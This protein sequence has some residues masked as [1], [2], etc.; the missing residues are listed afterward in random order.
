MDAWLRRELRAGH[1]EFAALMAR[2]DDQVNLAAAALLVARDAYPGL[3]VAR[4]LARLDEMAAEAAAGLAPGAGPMARL[5]G[6][7]EWYTAAGFQ[8]NLA[9]YYD[10]RN[11][12]LNE[13]LDRRLGIPITLGLVLMEVGRR[14][15]VPLTAAGLP[16]HVVV[17][18]A[19]PGEPFWLDPFQ[20]GRP[21]TA[22]DCRQRVEGLYGRALTWNPA[23]L[24]P[25]TPAA[26]LLRLLTN[27]RGAHSARGETERLLPVLEK[28]LLLA[29]HDLTLMREV[30]LLHLDEGRILLGARYLEYF[31]EHSPPS[32]DHPP[33]L[34]RVQRE[35]R[36]LAVLN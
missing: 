24:A 2:P 31:L 1:R 34:R 25:M 36:R 8:G 15:G 32:L 9:D 16:R 23:W 11:S 18:W 28:M 35:V 10:P 22:E 30:G 12:Y 7:I 17:G 3:A 33:L 29:P 13:V 26:F 4:Y 5:A 21:L 19:G 27:L 6:L 14:L 20:P